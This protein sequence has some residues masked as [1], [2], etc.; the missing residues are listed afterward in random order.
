MLY[1][2]GN[3]VELLFEELAKKN[4]SRLFHIEKKAMIKSIPNIQME[5]TQIFGQLAEDSSWVFEDLTQKDVLKK[6]QRQ[7]KW[8]A[9]L[10][11]AVEQRLSNH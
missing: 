7:M 4:G 9:I 1:K 6:L 2:G 10:L 8:I 5:L 3:Q 11:W